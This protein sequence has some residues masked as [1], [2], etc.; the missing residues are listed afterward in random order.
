MSHGESRRKVHIHLR[1]YPAR[2]PDS[3]LIAWLAQ[4]DGSGQGAKSEAIKEALLRGIGEARGAGTGLEGP[5]AK[6]EAAEGIP[7]LQALGAIR[8]VVEAAVTSALARSTSA[9]ILF[10]STSQ[11]EDDEV[12]TTLDRLCDD[13]LITSADPDVPTGASQRRIRCRDDYLQAETD[14]EAAA[15]SRRPAVGRNTGHNQ[16]RMW[17]EGD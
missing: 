6:A 12:Q 11:T 10:A 15:G 13:L 3:K 7:Q 8:Q 1:L 2:Q 9:T 17:A 4:F 5:G 16:K 14:T